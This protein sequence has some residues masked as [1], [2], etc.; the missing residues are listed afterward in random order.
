MAEQ[1]ARFQ[2]VDRFGKRLLG[3]EPSAD[4]LV[5]VPLLIASLRLAEE[6]LLFPHTFPES[7][8]GGIPALLNQTFDF[9]LFYLMLQLLMAAG[10]GLVCG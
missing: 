3:I 9:I 8:S 1:M 6:H 5:L 2:A 4:L 7:P 10:M